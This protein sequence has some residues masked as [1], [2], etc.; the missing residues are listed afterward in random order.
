MD[1]P[2]ITRELI[3]AA[4]RKFC[5][6]EGWTEMQAED[7][8][9]VCYSPHMNGYDLAKDLDNLRGWSPTAQDVETLD[10]FKGY[11]REAHKQECIVWARDN[12]VIPPFPIGTMTTQ[13][14]IV[15]IFA[16]DVACYEMR[17][18]DG[19]DPSW[20]YIVRFED[21]C[22]APEVVAS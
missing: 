8:A 13:G 12:N 6:L 9:R 7:L 15:G 1:R 14:E 4:A 20:R 3:A 21:A 18:P 5:E 19:L 11:L 16:H 22:A 17:K 10:N 2:K